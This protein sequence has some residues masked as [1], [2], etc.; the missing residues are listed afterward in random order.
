MIRRLVDTQVIWRTGAAGS[1]A[2]APLFGVTSEVSYIFRQSLSFRDC[3]YCIQVLR[4][5]AARLR[6]GYRALSGSLRLGPGIL[7]P[8]PGAQINLVVRGMIAITL[9]F[10]EQSV[11][12]KTAPVIRTFVKSFNFRELGRTG[13]NVGVFKVQTIRVPPFKQIEDAP[14]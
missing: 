10:N 12:T 3:V 6:F 13:G 11:G 2:C 5:S 1:E 14:G 7:R 9:A 4:Q 8:R